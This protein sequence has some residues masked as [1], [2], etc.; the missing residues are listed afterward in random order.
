MLAAL[1][2]IALVR[3]PA[4]A[5]SWEPVTPNSI[6]LRPML[7]PVR[8]QVF[9]GSCAVFAA[10]GAMEFHPGVPHLSEAYGYALLKEGALTLE[11]ANFPALREF[12]EATPMVAAERMPYELLG[13]FSFND[14]DPTE[15]AIGRAFN[16][17]RGEQARMLAPFAIYQARGVRDYTRDQIDWDWIER[18]LRAGQPIVMGFAMNGEHWTKAARG[19]IWSETVNYAD[20]T[21]RT[22]APDGGHAVLAVG[23]RTIYDPA[24]ATKQRILRQ[25]LIRNSWGPDWGDQGYGW[26]TWE[27]Y[28]SAHLKAVLTID[29][30]ETIVGRQDQ[31]PVIDL[32][33]QGLKWKAYNYSCVFSCVI[34][35]NYVPEG[36]IVSVEYTL[37]PGP[38]PLDQFSMRA[39]FGTQVSHDPSTAFRVVFDGLSDSSCHIRMTVRYRMGGESILYFPVPEICQW[40]PAPDVDGF[41]APAPAGG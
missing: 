5:Q 38:G 26:V 10:V 6:D 3:A 34:K 19:V 40:S 36:G 30:V 21:S 41:Q 9:R 28:A 11:G 29:R 12:F 4:G 17:K 22:F 8:D 18:T 27:T 35:S 15:L 14:K 24:D 1:M 32:R 37:Y 7:P 25:I 39:P 16:Q 31:A 2:V 23:Y 20:G 13:L 33:V